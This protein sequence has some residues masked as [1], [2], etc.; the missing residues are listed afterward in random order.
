MPRP[1]FSQLRPSDFLDDAASEP[2]PEVAAGRR[3]RRASRPDKAGREGSPGWRRLG[4]ERDSDH[5]VLDEILTYA[6]LGAEQVGAERT[7][8]PSFT[9]SHHERIWI[10]SYLGAY[11]D[12]QQITDV[13][14]RVKGG[15]EANVYCCAAHPAT[16]LELIAAKIYRPRMF[17]QLRNDQR[18]RQGRILLDEHGKEVRDDRLLHAV[19]KKTERGK[20]AEHA[21]WVEH[22]YQ[23]LQTL[24][25]AG[26]DVPQPVS[27]GNSTILMEFVGD[28][29]E[30]APALQAVSLPRSTARDIFD[31]LLYNV[32][33][34]LAHGRIHGDLSAFNVLFWDGAVKLIDFPQVVEPERNPDAFD[35]FQRDVVRLCQ[36]F[37]RYGLRADGPQIAGQ[38]WRRYG[39][40]P[41]APPPDPD[42]EDVG[43]A[44][45]GG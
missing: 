25:Q 34:M 35:I 17:R 23:A 30:P 37:A 18:Y 1:R 24:W 19:A 40:A 39:P 41:V 4:R 5:A 2:S 15:K 7:F 13:L 6:G 45:R 21:S 31:R 36:H 22:E 14:S 33:L 9:S 10:L 3:A 11:Y 8:S 44:R 38:L 43:A 12:D 29:N 32:E 27:H 42:D 26:A 28:R 20:A 16:G